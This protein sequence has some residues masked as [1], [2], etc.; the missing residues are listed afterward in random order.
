M[1]KKRVFWRNEDV[2]KVLHQLMFQHNL[3]LV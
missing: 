1:S 2:L 3:Y